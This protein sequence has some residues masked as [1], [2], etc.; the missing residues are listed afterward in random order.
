MGDFNAILSVEDMLHGAEVQDIEARDFR[1]FMIE[2]GM[3][4]LQT[5]GRTYTWSN[6]HTYSRIDRAIVNSIWMNK[7]APTPVQVTDPI[8]SDH[9][10]LSIE[11][12][13]SGTS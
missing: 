5:I 13:R 4:E 10:P 8:F 1:K 2:A 9:S 6:N 11:L 3:T 12:G 7:K